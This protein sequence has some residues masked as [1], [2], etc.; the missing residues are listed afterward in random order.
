MKAINKDVLKEAL[1]LV[2]PSEEEKN[3]VSAKI[4][5]FLKK[6]NK[7]LKIGKAELGGSGAKGTW[8]KNIRDADI[9]IK[10]DYKK[11]N[12][13]SEE[14]SGI[15]EKELRK[16]F[17]GV[18]RL[19]GS[20]D[21][22]QIR[23]KNFV[24][25]IIPILDIK[26]AEQARNITD[27]S[28][29]HTKWV[30]K[31]ARSKDDVILIKGF[32]KAEGVYGA[33]SYIKGFSGYATEILCVHY[34]GFKG[35]VKAAAKW[36]DK[37][38]IDIAKHHKHV[39]LEVNK[40]KSGGPLVLIDPVQPGRNAAAAL[41]N[42]KYNILR[43]KCREFLK[44]PAAKFF[45]IKAFELEKIMKKDVVIE[46]EP[47]EGKEDIVGSKLL[48]V[49]EK[50][51]K[52]LKCFG[53]KE[54]GWRWDEKAYMWFKLKKER[55]SNQEIREGPPER[56]EEHCKAFRKKYNDVFYKRGRIFA[57]VERKNRH[58]KDVLKEC[59]KDKYII[60]KV[61]KI[62]CLKSC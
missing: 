16:K 27:I 10:F 45:K 44:K 19:H 46:A 57:R 38:I 47:L 30:N 55:L 21:Y 53:I 3:K 11:Y 20:R 24:F 49:F 34:K 42:E 35:F 29:L 31:N 17:K 15:L 9:Y 54:K 37:E 14:I 25:E 56:L 36:R 7:G 26:K 60:E 33:E 48:K 62:R 51:A 32:C 41:S 40:S 58:A 59:F 22:F 23:D 39:M 50:L 61:K 18:K 5:E 13:R 1:K 52:E 8:T 2:K 43:K 28:P 6:I 12:K 4:D